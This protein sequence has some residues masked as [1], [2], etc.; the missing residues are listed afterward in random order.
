MTDNR[1][2]E[3]KGYDKGDKVESFVIG[4]IDHFYPDTRKV[5]W[6]K[7]E[8]EIEGHSYF[9]SIPADNLGMVIK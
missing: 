9:I 6:A 3:Y 5:M 4:K 7:L 2:D 8:L 1:K